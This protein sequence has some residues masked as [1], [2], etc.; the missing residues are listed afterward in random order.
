MV[1]LCGHALA[2]AKVHHVA[3]TDRA[4]PGNARADDGAKTI[5]RTGQHTAKQVVGHFRRGDVE[6]RGDE[7]RIDQFLE[8][9]ATRAGG[10]EDEAL[11]VAFDQVAN[12]RD[13]GCGHAEHGEAHRA[14]GVLA[15]GNTVH[16]HAGSGMSGVADHPPRDGVEA[17]HVC[18]RMH[19][20]DVGGAD[21][22]GDI[23]GCHGGDHQLRHANGKGP[24]GLRHHRGVA[25]A[26]QP[27]HGA[28]VVARQQKAAKRLRHGAHRLATVGMTQHGIGA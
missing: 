12:L 8:A 22:R 14:L 17:C 26:T 16:R 18:H 23:A 1:E 9:L 5:I 6:C 19:H 11:A 10:M 7:P 27:Q 21:V 28:D 20:H 4:H 13:A 25:A 15:C 3:G 24:H 2:P